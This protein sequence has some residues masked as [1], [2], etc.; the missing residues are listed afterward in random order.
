[1]VIK[2][3]SRIC[4]LISAAIIIAALLLTVFGHGINLGIDFEGGLSMQYDV[5]TAVNKAVI[6]TALDKMDVGSYVVTVQGAKDN[7]INVRIKDVAKDDIQ[8]LQATFENEIKAEY[9]EAES[10]GD[11]S[12]VGPVAGATLVRNAVVSVLLASLLMLIYIAIRFDLNSGLSAVFGLIH[13]VLIM[14]SFMV[15]FRS[16]IQMNSSFIAAALTIVGYSINNTI[17]IFD[18]IRENAKKMPTAPKEEVTNVSIRESLGR[19]IC[20]TVTTLITIVALCILGVA[21][22]RE[23]ALPIIVG[24]LAGMYSANLIN[25]YIWAWLEERGFPHRK[26]KAKKA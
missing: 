17:V 1:M 20:T 15:I 8:N 9:P 2:N 5:K 11:V 22:I 26:G 16:F 12:Y 24:I 21:S 19:T 4:L 6:E 10:I 23:F 3:R 14:L 18:R 7:E 25:G 13:D